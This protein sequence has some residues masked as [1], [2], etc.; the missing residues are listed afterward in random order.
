MKTKNYR[1]LLMSLMLG[2]IGFKG[3]CQNNG[4]LTVEIQG[5]E[6]ATG[7]IMVAV[8]DKSDN[9]LSKDTGDMLKAS[10]TEVTQTGSMKI[11]LELP[12]GE[13]GISS[14]H[15]QDADGELDT[16]LVGIPKEPVGFSNNAK[17]N[18][19]P[20]KYKDAKFSFTKDGQVMTIHIE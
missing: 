15:D 8:Y 6:K 12:F 7:F 16:N 9:F 17:I 4:V 20:P 13:Y 1:W 2:C 3:F 19:G 10:K 14:Y 18:F 11:P 5:I